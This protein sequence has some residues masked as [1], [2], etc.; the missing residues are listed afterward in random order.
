MKMAELGRVDELRDRYVDCNNTAIQQTLT[1]S[2]YHF[3]GTILH[4]SIGFVNTP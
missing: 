1:S 3:G 4:D 2:F